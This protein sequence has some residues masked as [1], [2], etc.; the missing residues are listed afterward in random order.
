VPAA[1]ALWPLRVVQLQICAVYVGTVVAK[2]PGEFW[3]DGTAVS[4]ALRMQDI[5]RIPAF[6]FVTQN[7]YLINTLTW[8][9][10]GFEILFPI[11]I[12]VN[13][14]RRPL[15]IG[16]LLLHASIHFVFMVGPFSIAMLTGY[17]AFL[18]A[19]QAAWWYDL[20]KRATAWYRRHS[21]DM[22]DDEG[23]VALAS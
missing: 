15:L 19:A 7:V 18:T 20:P 17:V 11:L 8:A 22:V 23:D 13:R 4:Y 9:T 21:P 10:I 14:A 3:L 6:D 5:T 12:W 16:G 2:A 1:T